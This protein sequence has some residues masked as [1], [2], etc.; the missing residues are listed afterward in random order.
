MDSTLRNIIDTILD[1]AGSDNDQLDSIAQQLTDAG[2]SSSIKAGDYVRVSFEGGDS[3]V[4]WLGEKVPTNGER[5]YNV[6][7]YP[8]LENGGRGGGS[9][10]F[11]TRAMISLDVTAEEIAA[12]EQRKAIPYQFEGI[13]SLPT[14]SAS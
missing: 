11:A 13:C 10:V 8:G 6:H 9:S 14:S 3:I 7:H 12:Y 4:G 5:C 1:S 2:Y